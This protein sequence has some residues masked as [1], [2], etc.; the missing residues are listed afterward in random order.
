MSK[1]IITISRQLGSGGRTVGRELAQRLGVPYYD[2]ELVKRVAAETGFDEGYIEQAGEYAPVQGWLSYA[3]SPLGT[4]GAME[5]MPAEDFLWAVQ[6]RVILD[7][8]GQG[9][10]VVAGRCADYI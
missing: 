5:G 1:Q 9:P 7:L 8:A 6:R 2:K 3:F 4:Q 10:C